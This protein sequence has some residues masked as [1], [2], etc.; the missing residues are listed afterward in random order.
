M[1]VAGGKKGVERPADGFWA[2]Q[3][4]GAVGLHVVPSRH[5]FDVVEQDVVHRD[6]A[7]EEAVWARENTHAGKRVGGVGGD[8]R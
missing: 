5:L 4:V 1:L 6:V 8:Q 3:G 2:Q 7:A